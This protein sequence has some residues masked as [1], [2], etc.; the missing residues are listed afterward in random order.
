MPTSHESQ[1]TA[2][3]STGMSLMCRQIHANLAKRDDMHCP[4]ISTKPMEDENKELKCQTAKGTKP[5][6]T[7]DD[8][9]YWIERSAALGLD[10]LHFKVRETSPE[11]SVY[12]DHAIA[13]GR[14][15]GG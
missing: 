1:Y 13:A 6:Y 15:H 9:A 7:D 8:L 4:H 10:S 14:R 2:F 3:D 12:T 5:G 11:M